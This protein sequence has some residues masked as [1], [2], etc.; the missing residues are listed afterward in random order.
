M[1]NPAV[2]PGGMEGHLLATT[3]RVVMDFGDMLATVSRSIENDGKI[4][5]DEA[6]HIRQAWETLKTKAE[7]L[8]VACEQGLY[9]TNDQ[10]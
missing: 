1:R 6:D 5:A 7:C 3:Q 9:A 2:T 4:T 10:P 8:V